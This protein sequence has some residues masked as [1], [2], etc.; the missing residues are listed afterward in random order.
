[1]MPDPLLI[2]LIEVLGEPIAVS[3]ADGQAL[4]DHIA[5]ILRSEKPVAL[6]FG[7]MKITTPTF[8]NAAVGQLYG[9]FEH[10]KLRALLSVREAEPH[11]LA[12]LKRVVENA[13]HYFATRAACVV[14]ETRVPETDEEE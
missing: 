14:T 13:K 8:L 5:P 6:C 3:A 7:G 2:R 10:D 9:E 11:D 4:H 1:M 12:L